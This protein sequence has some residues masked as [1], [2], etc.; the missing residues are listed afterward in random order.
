VC[1]M[2]SEVRAPFQESSVLLALGVLY[3][4]DPEKRRAI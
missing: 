1:G 3:A 4:C 2:A